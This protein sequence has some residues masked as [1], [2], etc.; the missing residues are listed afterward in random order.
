MVTFPEP[1]AVRLHTG[2]GDEQ[3]T[4]ATVLIPVEVE[5]LFLPAGRDV[6]ELHHLPLAEVDGH[7]VMLQLLINGRLGHE[8][9]FHVPG[10]GR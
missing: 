4:V 7:Q 6:L 3:T 10:G 2:S 8:E 9:G 5:V 1:H